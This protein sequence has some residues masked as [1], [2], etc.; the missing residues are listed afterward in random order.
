MDTPDSIEHLQR[1]MSWELDRSSP[2]TLCTAVSVR[3]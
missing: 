1:R 3:R 2:P